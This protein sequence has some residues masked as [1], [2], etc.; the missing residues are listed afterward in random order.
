MTCENI[1]D[2][3]LLQL[4]QGLRENFMG[5]TAFFS[6]KKWGVLG[7]FYIAGIFKK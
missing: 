5:K 3:R 7:G 6:T 4:H 2:R 1:T